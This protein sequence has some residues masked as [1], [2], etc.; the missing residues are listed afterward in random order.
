MFSIIVPASNEAAHIGACLKAILASDSLDIAQLIV[1]ANGCTDETVDIANSFS[2]QSQAR[3][4]EFNLLTLSAIGKPSALNA[5]DAAAK[6]PMRVYIDADVTVEPFLLRQITEALVVNGPRYASG[7]LRFVT[8]NSWVTRA[9][10][11]TYARVPFITQGVPGAGL[12]AVNGTGRK[13]WEAFPEIIADDTFV[14]LNFAPNERIGVSGQYYW[15]L[16]EGFTNLVRVRRRQNAG[17]KEIE[18]IY[19]EL[20][21]NDEK[22][23]LGLADHAKLFISD[24]V[25]FI[26]Y[27][28]VAL[29]VKIT[30]RLYNG[31]ER[32]R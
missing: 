1:V 12:F 11:R 6:Y 10:A 8:P 3:G 32:G 30:P 31:W 29:A 22:P 26:V 9:Y 17:V 28:G 24:P 16:V 4:W 5:G 25:G 7:Q 20:I 15:P 18:R 14:R 19:P 27:A 13:R 2:G 23:R 21:E